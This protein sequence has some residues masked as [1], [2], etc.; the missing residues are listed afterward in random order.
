ILERDVE[1]DAHE[2]ASPPG[3]EDVDALLAIGH[4]GIHAIMTSASTTRC[5]NPHSLSYHDRTLTRSPCMT[6]VDSA[7]NT[8]LCGL[9]IT[10]FDTMGSSQYSRIP[11][12]GPVA[13]AF[14]TA[15]TSSLVTARLTRH[16]RSTSE[17]S[18]TGTRTARPSRRPLSS[19]N[20]SPIAFAAPVEVG[21]MLSAAARA[22]RR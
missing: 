17:P 2:H 11:L 22:R 13:A 14:I 12:S 1:V 20:T 8:L 5:E 21:I 6:L 16:T 9:P 15:F 18:I 4:G 3:L 19:G 7:S 10:S